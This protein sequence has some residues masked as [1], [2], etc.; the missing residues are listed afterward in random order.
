LLIDSCFGGELLEF[1]VGDH[2]AWCEVTVSDDNH[3]K[4]IVATVAANNCTK[5]RGFNS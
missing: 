1:P 2:P 3:P 5:M 4:V